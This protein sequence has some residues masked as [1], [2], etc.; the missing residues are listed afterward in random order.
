MLLGRQCGIR[1]LPLLGQC[2]FDSTDLIIGLQRQLLPVAPLEEL[3]EGELQQRQSSHLSLDL[4]QEVPN[5]VALE[6]QLHIGKSRRVFD[7]GSQIGEVH[8]QYQPM[9]VLDELGQFWVL[10]GAIVEVGS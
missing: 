9:V 3:I 6:G 5:Q 7:D 8:G 10:D 4:E 2:A 1:R